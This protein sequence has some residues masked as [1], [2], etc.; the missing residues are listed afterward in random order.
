MAEGLQGSKRERSRPS[1]HAQVMPKVHPKFR[2][3]RDPVSRCEGG[4]VTL[5]RGKGTRR[6]GICGKDLS[7]PF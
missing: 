4:K 1:T 2:M 7:P 3:K 6:K 5:Q